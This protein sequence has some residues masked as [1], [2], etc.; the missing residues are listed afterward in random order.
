M[1]SQTAM[2]I[3]GDLGVN[4]A[5]KGWYTAWDLNMNF[6]PVLKEVES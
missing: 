4:F 1:H 2:Q 3:V 6:I 5:A